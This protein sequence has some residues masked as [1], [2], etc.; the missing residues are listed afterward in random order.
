MTITVKPEAYGDALADIYDLMFP[1][2]D[3][4]DMVDLLAGLT[5]PGARLVELG[6]GT[7]R[8]ALP[9][10]RRGFDVHGVDASSKMLA[11]LRERDPEHLVKTVQ[12]DL[13]DHVIDGNF[14]LCYIVCNTLFMLPDRQLQIR[15]LRRAA[16][17]VDVGGRV[18][19]EVYDP[20]GFH[21]RREPTVVAQQLRADRM[22][23]GTTTVDPVNQ[24]IV[25]MHTMLG[26]GTMSSYAEIS[27]YAWPPELDLMAELAGLR[28][29]ARWGDWRKTPFGPDSDR[30]V[31]VY[32]KV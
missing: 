21:N 19:V 25:L 17:H 14:D 9:A 30:H 27:R 24:I 2:A 18:V 32:E 1:A 28:R 6:V 29:V 10:A 20:S 23:I 8:V 4:D 12:A 22:L 7:G 5:R 26:P 13:S 16:E 31:S 15:A 11:K 3:V